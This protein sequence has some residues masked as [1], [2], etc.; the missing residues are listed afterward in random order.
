[1]IRTIVL[2]FADNYIAL[3]HYLMLSLIKF[4]GTIRT[5]SKGKS[6]NFKKYKAQLPKGKSMFYRSGKYV[7]VCWNDKMLIKLI[8][9]VFCTE[10][11][12]T[13]AR[14]QLSLALKNYENSCAELIILTK[15]CNNMRIEIDL[16]IGGNF[17]LSDGICDFQFYTI[18][19]QIKKQH[20]G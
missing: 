11:I 1:M 12:I 8:S 10:Y 18:Y 14:D 20:Y 17:F 6:F 7:L 3:W 13:S 4:V 15:C 2:I 9:N 16:R 19:A 5:I